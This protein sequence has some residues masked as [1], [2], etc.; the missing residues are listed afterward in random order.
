MASLHDRFDALIHYEPNSG[1]WL[2]DGHIVRGGYGAIRVA[3]T[4]KHIRAPRFSY[5]RTKGPIPEGMVIRHKCDTPACVNPDHLE[6]GSQADNARDSVSRNRTRR[7][8]NNPNAKLTLIQV[9]AIRA[10]RRHYTIIA[11]EH[12]VSAATVCNVRKRKVWNQ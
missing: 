10:D 6:T 12:G 5:E 11:A 1:C 2:W 4:K 3:E 9:A 8:Q 7:G